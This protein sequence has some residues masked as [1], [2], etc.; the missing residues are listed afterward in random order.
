M[1]SNGVFVLSLLGCAVAGAVV[2][3][4][5]V[6]VLWRVSGVVSLLLL[7]FLVP[8]FGDGSPVYLGGVLLGL[9]VGVVVLIGRSVAARVGRRRA[10]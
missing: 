2:V 5:S 10:E 8:F 3:N 6:G 4:S 7:A 9:L 1:M